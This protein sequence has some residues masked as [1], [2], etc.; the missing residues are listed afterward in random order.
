[1][2]ANRGL[3][4]L[5]E[6]ESRL[7]GLLTEAAAAGD[8]QAVMQ[9]TEWARG[10]AAVKSLRPPTNW[11]GPDCLLPSDNEG[12]GANRVSSSVRAATGRSTRRRKKNSGQ[13][14]RGKRKSVAAAYPKFA[15][16]Q[17]DLV[18]IGWSKKAK[19]EYQH[20]APRRVVDAIVDRLVEVGTD[21]QIFTT[22]QLLPLR[23][24]DGDSEIPLYQVYACLAWLRS[25]GVVSQHGRRG[26]STVR[27]RDA[28]ALI[29]ALWS[30]L[31]V[32]KA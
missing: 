3:D 9:L 8:Y 21:G 19:R 28:S 10:V 27:D 18:K 11:A 22:E 16:L 20:K 13:R 30:E 25:I 31:P 32:I 17:N 26:Y 29:E 12:N 15:R 6:C 1:M 5:Q 24:Q 23:D 2:S 4:A 14:A 7:R